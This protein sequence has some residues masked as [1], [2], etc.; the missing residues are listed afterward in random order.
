MTVKMS[1]ST[2]RRVLWS[3]WVVGALLLLSLV[4][5]PAYVA[6]VAGSALLLCLVPRARPSRPA[7][8]DR[9]DLVAIALLYTA[10]VALLR[11]AFVGFTT[12]RVAGLFLAFAAALLLGVAGPVYYMVWVRHRPLE[13]LGVSRDHWRATAV[14]ALVFAGVQF[15]ITLWGYDLPAAEDWVPLLVM[16]LVVGVFE[17][18]FFRGFVQNRLEEQFGPV[19]GIAVAAALYGAYHVGYGMGADEM[20]FLFGLGIVYAVAFAVTRNVL[21]LWPLLTPLGSFYSNVDAGDID[22]PWASIAGFADVLA[23][24]VVTLWLAHRHLRKRSDGSPSRPV[25]AGRPSHRG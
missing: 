11:L 6:A 25:T 12:D 18:I 4:S 22:L 19:V 8:G 10:V 20:I 7:R 5:G 23:L 2:Q 17:S 15:A 24:M 16:A 14:L 3:A 21:V 1:P 13:D 9:R